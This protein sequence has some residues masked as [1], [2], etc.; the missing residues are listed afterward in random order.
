MFCSDMTPSESVLFKQ[1]DFRPGAKA[2]AAFHHSFK[3][4]RHV[5]SELPK[6]KSVECRLLLL[7][8]EDAT[9][10]KARL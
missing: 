2:A 3:D 8:D 6:R 1:F 5:H 4:P 10:R 9:D 7:F